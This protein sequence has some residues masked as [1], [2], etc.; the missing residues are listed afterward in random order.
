ML[1]NGGRAEVVGVTGDVRT[2]GLDGH[3]ARTGDVPA[4]QAGYNFT[5]VVLKT[6][7]DPEGLAP[8]VRRLVRDM[9]PGLPLHHMRTLDQLLVQS[10][11]Q[12]RF[13]ML[14]VGA[15]SALVFA[16]AVVGT[17]GVASYA[18][19]E[20]T[21]ELAIRVALGATAAD[22]RRLVLGDG[23]RIALLGILI[24][25]GAAAARSRLL[26]RFVFQIST[27]DVVTFT[28]APVFDTRIGR[29]WCD[30]RKRVSC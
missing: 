16:L 11:A 26:A 12:Q 7:G 18:V 17:Y 1:P 22:I 13:Q 5:A 4:A 19:S 25:A 3:R 20:R 29:L 24:G 15:L 14:I 6:A 9:D 30:T 21:T 28:V 23:V 8:A 27:L 2:T 10:V